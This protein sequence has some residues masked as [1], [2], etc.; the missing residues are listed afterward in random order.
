MVLLVGRLMIEPSE[1]GKIQTIYV[2]NNGRAEP[3]TDPK[4]L[5]TRSRVIV[6]PAP[7]HCVRA[8]LSHLINIG[9]HVDATK[10]SAGALWTS[11]EGIKNTYYRMISFQAQDTHAV[12]PYDGTRYSLCYFRTFLVVDESLRAQMNEYGFALAPSVKL[13][14]LKDHCHICGKSTKGS[15]TLQCDGNNR[16]CTAEVHSSCLE[17]LVGPNFNPE[18]DWFCSQCKR[19]DTNC[20]FDHGKLAVTVARK[21]ETT[22]ER[23]WKER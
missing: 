14:E 11:T 20:S 19:E 13:E 9:N 4:N 6:L 8:G 22:K 3:H 18:D 2:I 23:R 12:M 21:M 7:F 1:F 5:G 10:P 17:R 16:N 15:H